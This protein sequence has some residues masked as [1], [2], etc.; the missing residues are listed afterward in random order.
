SADDVQAVEEALP[1][2][3][4]PRDA[5][6]L[7]KQLVK[8]GRLTKYQA[9]NAVQGK[10]K[11][12]VFDDYV[13]LD[14]WPA[15][16]S[17]Q[18]YQ[19]EHRR[20]KRRVALRLL[21]PFATEKSSTAL[22]RFQREVQAAARLEHSHLL[23]AYHAGEAHGV[24][25]L[26][27]QYVEGQNLD[28]LVRERGPLPWADAVAY[29]TQAA[30][31]LSYAHEKGVVHRDVKPA[32]MLLDQAGAIKISGLG[33]ARIE[34]DT[35]KGLTQ[36]GELIGTPEYMSPE[37]G[38]DA[39]QVDARSDI[40]SLGCT[41]YFFL[42]GK[43]MYERPT[44]AQQVVAHCQ[45]AIPLLRERRADVP[46]ALES[47]FSKMVAK[48]AA[49]RYPS[50]AAVVAAL[51][52]VQQAGSKTASKIAQTVEK[53]KHL[54]AKVV[55]GLFAT[56]VAPMIVVFLSNYLN[57]PVGPAPA[58]NQPGGTPNTTPPAAVE[59]KNLTGTAAGGQA[60]MIPAGQT[61]APAA[62]VT[63]TS[64]PGQSTAP[65][66]PAAPAKLEPAQPELVFP[67]EI[68]G[69]HPNLA[70]A[71]FPPKAAHRHQQAW[72][73][74]LN[75]PQ[76]ADNTLGMSLLL[77]PPGEFSMGSTEKQIQ[78]LREGAKKNKAAH[79]KSET[80]QHRVTLARPFYM[81]ATEVTIGQFRDFVDATGYRTEVERRANA[82]GTWKLPDYTVNDD[83]PVSLVTWNDAVEFCNWLSDHEGVP[84]A[85]R[86]H[87]KD[88]WQAAPASGYRLPS[89]AQW[90]FACRAGTTTQFSFGD[91]G[92][93]LAKYAWVGGNSGRRAHAVGTLAQNA[94]GL[95]DMH[96]NVNEWCNDWYDE[97]YYASS[98]A[99][100]PEGPTSGVDR[101]MR[102]IGWNGVPLLARSACRG[103]ANPEQTASLR[104]FRVVRNGP[105]VPLP[106]K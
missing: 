97:R 33:L 72:S 63:A 40:Y 38:K 47:V 23:A 43:P 22:A 96:G 76:K 55:G 58:P 88:I 65:G 89:E 101:V 4:R 68:K 64:T 20:M 53:T 48:S 12:L 44:P 32:N 45:Q 39:K 79:L 75:V 70:A 56:I 83:S 8:A 2:E 18:L 25:Y 77:I 13:V 9:A 103:F 35:E 30:R 34:D 5:Q 106:G 11:N 102:G 28:A 80:P 67:R 21:P 50:M 74:Y 27:L 66:K 62:S 85:Y 10:A 87:K 7:A 37:Q 31:A 16:G 98:G 49:E 100:N 24:P 54:T 84:R 90:E 81:S 82:A 3:R 61:G 19:A 71:P 15:G 1:P 93:D 59:G 6:E 69:K 26:V 92:D 91:N 14:T 60:A 104:G 36:A 94:F 57:T 52:R 105:A 73:K 95:F 42:T 46:A 17:S 78:A 99:V 41:L 51:D 29:V 86:P